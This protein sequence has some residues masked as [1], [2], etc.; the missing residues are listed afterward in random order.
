MS[1]CFIVVFLSLLIGWY[2]SDLD[3]DKHGFTKDG[4]SKKRSSG[5]KRNM[6]ALYKF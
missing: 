2:S 1:S 4:A 3:S 6:V 5:I